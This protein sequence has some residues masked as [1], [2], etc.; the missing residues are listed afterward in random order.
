[1]NE[2]IDE[3]PLILTVRHDE[4]MRVFR[5]TYSGDFPLQDVT[6]DA[7]A[8]EQLD[9]RGDRLGARSPRYWIRLKTELR[10]AMCTDDPRYADLRRDF[11]R[12]VVLSHT[13]AV[14][15]VAAALALQVGLAAGVITPFC[16]LALAGAVKVGREAYC[17]GQDLAVP[18]DFRL[19]NPRSGGP[20]D[21]EDLD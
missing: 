1:M 4:M 19:L 16:A 17:A 15:L 6:L 9:H 11:R 13:S 10:L 2:H 12:A 8:A 21:V 3:T 14:S 18:L 20:P 5:D 7:F